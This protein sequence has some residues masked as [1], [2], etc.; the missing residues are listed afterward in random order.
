MITLLSRQNS[1]IC[2]AQI[3]DGFDERIK[4]SLQIKRR[5]A[6]HLWLRHR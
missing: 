5:A 4:Y 2:V 3:G 1:T 6:D